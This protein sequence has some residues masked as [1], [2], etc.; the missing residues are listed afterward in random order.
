[1][2]GR[3]TRSAVGQT[4]L[5]LW[6]SLAVACSGSSTPT[7]P[8]GPGGSEVVGLDVSCPA[9]LLPGQQGPCVAVR[10]LRSGQTSAVSPS[11]VWSSSQPDVVAVD[12]IGTVQGRSAGQAVI[13]ARYGGR[14]GNTVSILVVVQDALRV[15]A[16]V[17]QGD[18]RRG[19]TVT[20]S[21]LGHYSV[22][23]AETGRLSLMISDQEGPITTTLPSTVNNGGSSFFLSSS[24]VVPQR[25]DQVCRT[26][27]LEVGS[28]TLTEPTSH[29]L[30]LRCIPVRP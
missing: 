6:M 29:A 30:E 27:I 15:Q 4:A 20:L 24:F 12:A 8:S 22:A 26:A 25:S 19:S 11:A 28:V 7:S 16:A 17:D 9:T 21:L 10:R 23:S 3:F 2:L 14:E 18:F 13:S 5:I 1:M